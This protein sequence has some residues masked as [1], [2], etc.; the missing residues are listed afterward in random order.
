[1]SEQLYELTWLTGSIEMGRPTNHWVQRGGYWYQEYTPTL[2]RDHYG[3]V[4]REEPT[5]AAIGIQCDIRQLMRA[6][7][8]TFAEQKL[9]APVNKSWMR[10][11]WDRLTH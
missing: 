6:T 4:V 9:D 1:M 3:K 2:H 5:T 8:G 11:L 7:G 10:R